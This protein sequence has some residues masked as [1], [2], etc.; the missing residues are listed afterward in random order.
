MSI[1]TAILG[2]G[3]S[4]SSMHAGAI[5][6]N[7]PFEMV[8]ACDIDPERQKQASERFGCAIYDDYHEML[9]KEELDLVT[10]VTRSSQHCEMVCD[11]LKAGVNVLVTKPW[12]VNASEASQMCAAAE[13]S[14][15]LLVPWLPS[16]WGRDLK[17]LKELMAE[18]VIG[19]VFLIRRAV[20][21]FGTRCDWQTEKQYG[22]GYLLNWGPHIVDPPVVLMGS[23]V[24]SVY[25]RLKQ[26]IN[27]GDVEDMFLAI[28]NLENGTV[29][30][31]EYSVAVESLANWFIQGDRGTIVIR[32]GKLTIYKNT[33][34]R[35]D[36]PT[37]YAAMKASDQEV[38]EETLE[39][40][41][42]GDEVQVYAEAA[43][44]LQGEREF[45]VK[46]AHALELSRVLDAIRASDEQN[47][48]VSL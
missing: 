21:S 16:R 22:G 18:G 13:A 11:C 34:G 26:T 44:A 15:K 47:R 17:R 25:G 35:P 4:G 1:R 33:P 19:N 48:V 42:Y 10:V 37:K 31:A 45:P 46:P 6:K 32:G 41:Q 24:K 14:G 36:D 40:A 12:A 23:P 9:D 38:I 20:C 3:R 30:Q 29:V 2:Y 27:P 39:G 5:E 28:M 7:E 43:R 8:A